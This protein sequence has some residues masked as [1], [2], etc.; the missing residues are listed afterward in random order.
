MAIIL[1]FIII[2]VNSIFQSTILPY[3]NFLGYLPNTSI[4]LIIGIALLR[5]KYYGGF[6]GLAV[7]L[8]QD[9]LF[10]RVIGV[11][12]F[13]YFILGYIVGYI[14]NTL[15][16]E[17]AFIPVVFSALG[18]VF[19]NLFYFILMYFLAR[20]ISISTGLYNIFSIEILYNSILGIL[21]YKIL[22]KIF[23]KPSL[24]FGR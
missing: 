2:I 18:T 23:V 22:S 19:Y 15:N 14:K 17:N 21:I 10:S 8:I 1:L 11:N 24:R 20:D 7:G 9:I 16:D 5:G 13:I 3:F 4:V 12:A 6:F